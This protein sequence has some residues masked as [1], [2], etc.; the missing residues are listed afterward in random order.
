MPHIVITV[1]ANSLQDRDNTWASLKAIFDGIVQAGVMDNDDN[2]HC[3][4]DVKQVKVKTRAE[5]GITITI[6]KK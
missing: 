4:M 6:S 1:Y 3:T 2:D 5:E